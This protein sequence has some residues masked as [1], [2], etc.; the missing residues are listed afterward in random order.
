MKY[1]YVYILTN[2][3][4]TVL[5]TGVS[6]NLKTRILQHK[7]KY[8][9]GFTGKY[10]VDMLVYYESCDGIRGAIEREKQIKNFSR[11][12]KEDLINSMNPDWKDLCS[13]I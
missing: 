5:Y 12:K 13:E 6:S 8:H 10:N 4:H 7:E 3:A 11:E 2:K 1:G 9:S